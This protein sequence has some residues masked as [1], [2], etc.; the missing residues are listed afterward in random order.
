MNNK[1]LLKGLAVLITLLSILA[2]SAC[3]QSSRSGGPGG[4]QQGPPPEAIE[5]CEGKAEGDTVSFSG[6]R[7]DTIEATCQMVDDQL[8]A[9]PE[10]HEERMQQRQ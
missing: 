10:G 5:V 9:V 4:R 7:G 1:T 6:R 8:V 2:V 3:A